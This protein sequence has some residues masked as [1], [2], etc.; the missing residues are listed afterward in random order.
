MYA[1]MYATSSDLSETSFHGHT[2]LG[3][4]QWAVAEHEPGRFVSDIIFPTRLQLLFRVYLLVN[5]RR[6]VA[7]Q[8]IGDGDDAVEAS[9]TNLMETEE[10]FQPVFFEPRP[11][12]NLVLIDEMESLSPITDLK[13]R[14]SVRFRRAGGC[15]P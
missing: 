11:L 13:V 1:A 14:Q 10:G 4:E 6:P 15:T 12:R 9:S 8:G 2:A 5:V 3:Y 7:R